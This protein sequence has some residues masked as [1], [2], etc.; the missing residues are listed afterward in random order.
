MIDTPKIFSSLLSMVISKEWVALLFYKVRKDHHEDARHN[1]AKANAFL[2]QIDLAVGTICPL[3]VS[4]LISLY[5]YQYVLMIEVVQHIIGAVMIIFCIRRAVSL[6]PDLIDGT[7]ISKTLDE[8]EERSTNEEKGSTTGNEPSDMSIQ[9]MFKQQTTNT[10]LISVAY[11]LLYFTILS[12]GAMLNAWMNSMNEKITETTIA[13]FGSISQFCGVIATFV[14]PLL[15][16]NTKTLQVASAYSQWFQTI[17]IWYGFYCFY[18]LNQLNTSSSDIAMSHEK[19][20]ASSLMLQFL[21]SIGLSRI[22]LWS[23]DLVERQI[24]QQS[25]PKEHQTLFFNGERSAT[26]FLSLCM[27]A[28]CYIFPD[29]DTFLVLVIGSVMA[30]SL[31][32]VLIFIQTRL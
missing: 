31:S 29:P 19:N 8:K 20:N 5:G 21:I 28:M 17:C 26:Q 18:Q 22:G 10:K 30:V 11:I 9:K 2:S 24:L 1:L 12:P 15:I 7:Y 6:C 32:S 23:F 14:T 25:V 3:L 27:M 16:R 4:Y 13:Y